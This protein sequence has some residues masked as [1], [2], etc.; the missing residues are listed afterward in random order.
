MLRSI[1]LISLALAACGCA[2]ILEG[3]TQTL[4]VE[5]HPPN[6]T[7]EVSRQGEVLGV[8]TPD[9]RTLMMSK[10]QYDLSFTCSAPGYQTK[11]ETLSSDLSAA[12]VASFLLLDL[13]IVDA[14][15]GAWKKYPGR[16][17]IILAKAGAA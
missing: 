7:C 12:T 16:V 6:G 17:T 3:P 1:A 4:T 9:R 5:V 11:T 10:S 15:T 8:S 13:G 14:A 2:T